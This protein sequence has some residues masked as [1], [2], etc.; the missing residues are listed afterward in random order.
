MTAKNALS[1]DII[2]GERRTLVLTDVTTAESKLALV[3]GNSNHADIV[4]SN[5]RL[6]ACFFTFDPATNI[7][8]HMVDPANL[9]QLTRAFRIWKVFLKNPLIPLRSLSRNTETF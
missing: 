9:N 1:P 8:G 7:P 4:V 6:N 5:I 2:N 3:D